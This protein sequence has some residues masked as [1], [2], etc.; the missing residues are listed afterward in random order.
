MGGNP[1]GERLPAR[2]LFLVCLCNFLAFFSIYMVVPVLPV[3]LEEKGYS[4]AL[5]GLLMAVTTVMALLR[6]FFGRLTDRHGRKPALT[7]GVFV[8]GI[9]TF[10]H[11]AFGTAVPLL[12][13]RFLNGAGLA[14]FHTAA[15]AVVGDLAPSSRRLQAIAFFYI[16]VDVSIALAPLVAEAVRSTLG[17]TPVYA[18]AG[19]MSVLSL[20]GSLLVRETGSNRA[21]PKV[22]SRGAS[23][24]NPLHRAVFLSTMGFTLTFGSLQYFIVLSSQK[25]GVE[26]GELFFTV[27]AATLILFRLLLGRRADRIPRR[28]LISAS[29]V[30]TLSGLILLAFAGSLLQLLLGSLVYALGFAYLP[31]TFSALLLDETPAESRGLVLGIFLA[32]FD[33]GICL[34]GLA[35]GPLADLLGYSA[36]Y[37]TGGVLASMG[38]IYFRVVSSRSIRRRSSDASAEG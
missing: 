36:M 31:T 1:A 37:A 2:D 25:K 5:I 32:V 29:A 19:G 12:I 17:Y 4:N 3:F 11:A 10:L 20:A 30:V 15:Y 28:A 27:F 9:T 34:G 24:L 33:L 14:A 6:P 26:Q 21:A 7:W 16:S 8:L 38:L 22:E 18:L 35:M 23:G 13:V